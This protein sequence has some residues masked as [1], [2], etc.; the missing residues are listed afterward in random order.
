MC[1]NAS[2]E[3]TRT[4]DRARDQVFLRVRSTCSASAAT[5]GNPE[6]PGARHLIREHCQATPHPMARLQIGCNPLPHRDRLRDDRHVSAG[7]VGG[8]LA[9]IPLRIARR[10]E[11]FLGSRPGRTNLRQERAGLGRRSE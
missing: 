11:L 6:C 8:A 3:G 10:S 1:F 5:T 2:L 9:R 4:L 7:S